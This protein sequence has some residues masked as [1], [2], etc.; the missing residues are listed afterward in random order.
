M[1]LRDA[2][3]SKNLSFGHWI[4]QNTSLPRTARDLGN[5]FT[6]KGTELKRIK[7]NLGS[8]INVSYG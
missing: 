2:S 4:A 6:K 3:A 7:I 1:V 5:F 8:N